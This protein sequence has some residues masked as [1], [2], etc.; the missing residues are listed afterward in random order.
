MPRSSLNLNN[1]M[2]HLRAISQRFPSALSFSDL[3]DVACH[4]SSGLVHN[5]DGLKSTP[6]KCEGKQLLT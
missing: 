3:A 2:I 5:L 1:A 6:S 4:V